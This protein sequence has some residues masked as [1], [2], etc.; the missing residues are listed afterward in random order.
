[1]GRERETER[2]REKETKTQRETKTKKNATKPRF[3]FF[4]K[5]KTQSRTNAIFILPTVFLSKR[6]RKLVYTFRNKQ[7]NNLAS[8]EKTAE[9]KDKKTPRAASSKTPRAASSKT[10]RA[11]AERK[12]RRRGTRAR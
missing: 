3:L 6:E 4:P 2:E 8:R 12:R 5:A 9:C 1:M 7:T 11:A 10:P